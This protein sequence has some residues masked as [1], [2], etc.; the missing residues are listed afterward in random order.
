MKVNGYETD[1]DLSGYVDTYRGLAQ[2]LPQDPAICELGV[3]QGGSLALWQEL[4]PNASVIVGVDIDPNAKWPPG[5]VRVVE[6]QQSPILPRRL[7]AH[8]VQMGRHD[9]DL[10]VDDA[11]HQ[12]Q[13]TYKAL[14]HLWPL[15]SPGGYYAIEDWCVWNGHHGRYDDSMLSLAMMLPKMFDTPETNVHFIS[16]SYGMIV[17]R[18]KAEV[19]G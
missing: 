3:Y 10:I 11:S 6:D 18:K 19:Q 12:G 7:E 13:L 8:A 16:F 14:Q 4:F 1:K 17:I 15:V 2:T 9:Y 5:T